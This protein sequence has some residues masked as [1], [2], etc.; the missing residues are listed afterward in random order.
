MRTAH[1]VPI[2]VSSWAQVL[3]LP[4]LQNNPSGFD[5]SP[6]QEMQQPVASLGMIRFVTEH[7]VVHP[8]LVLRRQCQV[9][10]HKQ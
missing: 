5:Q 9:I 8:F 6:T 2:A 7:I 1:C 10:K 4:I 3:S